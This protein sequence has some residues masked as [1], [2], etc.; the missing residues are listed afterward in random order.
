MSLELEAHVE[1][2]MEP[3]TIDNIILSK[4]GAFFEKNISPYVRFAV[5]KIIAA[6]SD[7]NRLNVRGS[8][9][10][11]KNANTDILSLSL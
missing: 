1:S 10:L 7:P 5:V 11:D 3:F 4:H 8:H 9:P 6:T 2:Y